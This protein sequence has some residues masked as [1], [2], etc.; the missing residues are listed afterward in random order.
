MKQ[1]NNAIKFLMAQYRAIFKNA[2][3]KGLTSAVLLT[4]GLAAGQ[5]QA[6]TDFSGTDTQLPLLAD[7]DQTIT[8]V[9]DGAA[10]GTHNKF[11]NFNL[12]QSGNISWNAEVVIE[13]GS[14][15]WNGSGNFLALP[16]GA[17]TD[18]ATISGKG[19]LT[20]NGGNNIASADAVGLNIGAYK[21]NAKI[22][23]SLGAINVLA[24]T[25]NV[26]DKSG[27][28]GSLK[29]GSVTIEADTITVG[30]S[31]GQDG[32]ATAI[33][34]LAATANT[35]GVG[36]TLGRAANQA[37]GGKASE[38]TVN[39]G[40]VVL[41]STTASGDNTTVLGAQLAVDA[42][43]LVAIS[44]AAGT[45]SIA[46]DSTLIEAEGGLYV[47]NATILSSHKTDING[48]LLISGGN[49]TLM[50]APQD[51]NS[52]NT[53]EAGTMTIGSTATVQIADYILLQAGTGANATGPHGQLIVEDGAKLTALADAVSAGTSGT[54]QVKGNADI[55]T[56]YPNNAL[57]KGPSITIG[58]STLQGFLNKEGTQTHQ[59]L[60]YDETNN[61]LGIADPEAEP[62][63][64][65]KGGLFLDS[66]GV[67]NFSDTTRVDLHDFYFQSGD[68][69]AGAIGIG[70]SGGIVK[71]K[72]LAVSDVL[73]GTDKAAE[74]DLALYLE[75][76]KLTLGNADY[77]GSGSLG[78]EEARAQD[79]INFVASGNTFVLA[80]TVNADRDYFVQGTDTDGNP[81]NTFTLNGNGTITGDDIQIGSGS[82][83]G[84][85]NIVGGAWTSDSN[86]TIVSGSLAVTADPADSTP[87]WVNN[88]NPASLTLTGNVTLNGTGDDKANIK[89]TGASGADATLDLTK[90]DLVLDAAQSGS[91]TV[92][93]SVKE[94]YESSR[95]NDGSPFGDAA[96]NDFYAQHAT[97]GQIGWGKLLLNDR[98]FAE[99]LGNNG[100]NTKFSI[101]NGGYVYVNGSLT[102]E[103]SFEKFSSGTAAHTVNFTGA[104]VLDINGTLNLYTGDPKNTGTTANPFDIGAG[105]IAADVIDLHN[106][107]KDRDGNATALTISGGTLEVRQGLSTNT[108]SLTFSG[109]S[110]AKL[111]LAGDFSDTGVRSQGTITTATNGVITLGKSGAISVKGGDWNTL[112]DIDVTGAAS[113][114]YSFTLAVDQ[115]D[116]N[117]ADSLSTDENTVYAATF[118]GDNFKANQASALYVDEATRATF[119]TMQLDVTGATAATVEGKVV[120]NGL[121]GTNLPEEYTNKDKNPAYV[122]KG[123]TAG[124]DLGES[125]IK[126]SG[127]S[128][129]FGEVA[130]SVLI[131]QNQSGSGWTTDSV[132]EAANKSTFAVSDA[133]ADA[134]FQISDFGELKFNLTSKTLINKYDARFLTSTLL[135]DD[136]GGAYN[137]SSFKGY[138]NLGDAELDIPFKPSPIEGVQQVAWDE[139]KDFAD[140]TYG[141]A[142]T[143]KMKNAIITNIDSR[144]DFVKGHYGSLQVDVDPSKTTLSIGG[145]VSLHNA[146]GG[147]FVFSGTPSADGTGMTAVGVALSQNSLELED[148][149]KIGSISGTNHENN[150]VYFHGTGTTEVLGSINDINELYVDNATTVNGD[151]ETAYLDLTNTLAVVGSTGTT[152]TEGNVSLQAGDLASTAVLNANDLSVGYIQNADQDVESSLDI[153]GTVNLTGD[154]KIN[155]GHDVELF[156]GKLS[157]VNVTLADATANLI[158]GYEPNEGDK[159]DPATEYYNEARSYGGLLEVTGTTTLNGGMLA[160]DPDYAQSAAMASLNN[161]SHTSTA[162]VSDLLAGSLDGKLFVGQNA[163]LG[164]GSDSLATLQAK[165][166]KFQNANGAFNPEEIGSIVYL[167]KSFDI[168]STKAGLILTSQ[169]IEQFIDTFNAGNAANATGVFAD[170]STTAD[171]ET[172][173]RNNLVYLGDNTAIL[174]DGSVMS[175]ADISLGEKTEAVI[176][177]TGLTGDNRGQVIADGGDII[178]DGDVRAST[179]QVFDKATATIS[180][181]DGT[182]YAEVKDSKAAHYEDNINVSTENDFLQGVVQNDGTVI[183]GVNPNGRAIMHGASDP[184][185]ASLVAYARGYNGEPTKDETTGNEVIADSQKLYNGY[186][187]TTNEE[188]NAVKTP[189]YGN[190]KNYFLQ[191]TIST[192][193]GS[194]AEAV[195]RLAV[196]GGAAQAAISAGASTYDA[197]SGRM[198]VGAN[199][200]NI[201]VAD[202]TQGAALWLAPIY[203]SSDSDGFDAEGVD[204]GVDMDLYGV[205]LGA[206]YTLSN[207]IRFGAMFNVGS[208]EVDGQGAGSAVSNDFDYYGFAVYGGYSMGALSVVADVSYTVAD[209]DLEGNTSIDKVGASLDSTN[210]SVGVTGQYQLDFNGTTVTPHAG[211]RFSR[212]DLDDYTIDGEDIIADYDADSMNIFS[213]PVGVTFAKEFTSDTWTVKPSLDLTL[214]GNFGDDETDGTVHWAGVENLSTNVSS[215][216]LDNFTYG[217]TLGVA[218]KTGNFSLG[219]GVNYTGSSNVD[220]FGVNANAR[221]V[222]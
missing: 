13:S 104:G 191:E 125:T 195:A 69:A 143:E 74:E 81:I 155:T 17:T 154:L 134:H 219:L 106:Y 3:F 198:G 79:N 58:S 111:T 59:V 43:G 91:I 50:P 32:E 4:A 159:D 177:F 97:R 63:K 115:E 51:T 142:T 11:D 60:D 158:V 216:V 56:S 9:S 200:A 34:S 211:L 129:E 121:T 165:V 5:A 188:G 62:T 89:V 100:A 172:T 77:S 27:E 35:S 90:A 70:A 31:A 138:L 18:G 10:D 210:L 38:I 85:L 119:N 45:N 151:V 192:G 96:T 53:K 25:L 144:N 92:S 24:G 146:V 66:G 6:A 202:N 39:E 20:I 108:D 171:F 196:Y 49:L 67:L 203:K 149:G 94:V 170:F 174:V 221:F 2:Y 28:S 162:Q 126:I 139:V 214:T 95:D 87:N 207:G 124:I 8:I 72:D 184:V 197:V 57:E 183:L 30:D 201:T 180:Y 44:G 54:I 185:Y 176:S 220:E 101:G 212:I 61:T 187:E 40:G 21:E 110:T 122:N 88:G 22:N 107:N 33:L 127:G 15:Q 157:A 128:F 23:I 199:G 156:N 140:L 64:A 102:G 116:I 19:S 76:D 148:G 137:T 41:L 105:T 164:I 113:N 130:S 117:L 26:S 46:T 118:T 194:A 147:Y 173:L 131:Q 189:D 93:G 84:S 120:V 179:Y 133:I 206:D 82:N 150:D 48:N 75:A 12:Q 37:T 42:G 141:A 123:T 205:A 29:S 73:L 145:N 99:F 215:E 168:D 163:A 190:Y 109:D 1:T 83:S 181:L 98:D 217:A 160:V 153:A 78:F 152:A 55:T 14:A 209:N 222:F 47:G 167:G 218:A 182:S 114:S 186:V 213:I 193:D 65:S 16:S 161:L 136:N 103:H 7:P 178:I 80:D 68:V 112:A 86:I 52:D 36:L 169:S 132:N 71:G 208:G 135:E 166:A 204:Y 175:A